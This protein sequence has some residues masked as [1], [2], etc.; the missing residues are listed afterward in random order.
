MINDDD[1]DDD[2]DDE[3]NDILA[4]F[5][6]LLLLSCLGAFMSFATTM[7]FSSPDNRA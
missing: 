3:D 2:D 7:A 4:I 1:D 5:E 6:E